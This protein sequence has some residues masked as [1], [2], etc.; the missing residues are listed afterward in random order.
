MMISTLN[1]TKNMILDMKMMKMKRRI[2][3]KKC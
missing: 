1:S 3:T 2:L